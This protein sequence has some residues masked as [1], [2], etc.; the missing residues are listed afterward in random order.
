MTSMMQL[1]KHVRKSA[2]IKVS[3]SQ[4]RILPSSAPAHPQPQLGAEVVLFPHSPDDDTT[5]MTTTTTIQ[6]STF[7]CKNSIFLSFHV[8]K[9]NVQ[10]IK[11][12]LGAIPV[13]WND[14]LH[15]LMPFTPI[16][17]SSMFKFLIRTWL[18][19]TAFHLYILHCFSSME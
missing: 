14:F 9:H 17:L 11:I 4:G 2:S 1:V 7:L 15:Q 10:H 19:M 6:N 12:I 13:Q 3:W 8:L 16:K 18:A 5:T